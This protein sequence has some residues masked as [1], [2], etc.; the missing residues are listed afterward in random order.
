MFCSYSPL[1]LQAIH[2]AAQSLNHTGSLMQL[3]P[4]PSVCGGDTKNKTEKV[5][6]L[7]SIHLSPSPTAKLYVYLPLSLQTLRRVSHCH[8]YNHKKPTSCPLEQPANGTNN[9][10]HVRHS[11]FHHPLP[12][13]AANAHDSSSFPLHPLPP[14]SHCRSHIHKKLTIYPRFHDVHTTNSTKH[15]RHSASRQF[16]QSPASNTHAYSPHLL[17]SL[18]HASHWRSHTQKELTSYPFSQDGCIRNSIKPVNHSAAHH[19]LL[20]PTLSQYAYSS[21]PFHTVH[22]VSQFCSTTEMQPTSYPIC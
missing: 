4:Y 8:K 12:S 19:I 10:K 16:I 6:Y 14:A 15:V 20:S 22:L 17:H 2:S 9:I 13:P 11:A 5:S 18:R 7:T 1:P 3:S 21:L